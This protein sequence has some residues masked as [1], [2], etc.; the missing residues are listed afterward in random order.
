MAKKIVYGVLQNM[1]DIKMATFTYSFDK[2]IK[3]IK[4]MK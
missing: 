2:P 4:S 1:F 3:R